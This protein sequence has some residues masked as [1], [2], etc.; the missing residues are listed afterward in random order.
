[1]TEFF[2]GSHSTSWSFLA[3]PEMSTSARLIGY[4]IDSN[5]LVVADSIVLKIEDYL[6][7]EVNE[8][9]YSNTP[10]MILRSL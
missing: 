3:S 10:T 1:M 7:T 8:Q 6:P 2:E 4:Y 5:G 9:K